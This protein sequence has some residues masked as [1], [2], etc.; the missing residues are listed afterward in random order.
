ME[1]KALDL[2]KA[3]SEGKLPLEGGY[4]VTSFFQ[5]NSTYAKYELLAYSGAKNVYL[6]EEG[7]V[8]QTD[9]NK[10]FVLAE[11]ASYEQRELEPISRGGQ[12]QIPHSFSELEQITAGNMARI[13][14]SRQPVVVYFSFTIGK[15]TALSSSMLFYNLPDALDSI[16]AYLQESLAAEAGLPAGD[17]AA[18]AG[19]VVDGL[20]RFPLWPEL[21][22]KAQRAPEAAPKAVEAAPAPL[23]APVLPPEPVLQKAAPKKPAP[24]KAAAGKPAAK[25]ARPKK[26]AV[27][28]AAVKKAKKPAVKKAA[29]KVPPKRVAAKKPAA[30]KPKAKKAPAKKASARRVAKKAAVKKP[31][32]KPAAKRPAAK[33]RAR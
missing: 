12:Q 10:L 11:P 4:I 16:S 21:A 27:K 9:A 24:K 25:K 23:A 3:Y 13:L 29:K 8:F 31:V 17:A 33:K 30:K 32:R 14:F 2:F 1:E 18:A 6:A 28:K 20:K 26:A 19:L 22:A 5:E 15:P 7:L